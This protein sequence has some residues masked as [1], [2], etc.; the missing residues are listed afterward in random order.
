MKKVQ[1]DMQI[2]IPTHNPSVCPNCGHCPTCGRQD[3]LPYNPWRN[4]PYW[5]YQ[6][7]YT[8]G[9]F[10]NNNTYEVNC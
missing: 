1:K 3:A 4:Q 10:P 6:P 2:S 9:D 7:T 8:V 5:V